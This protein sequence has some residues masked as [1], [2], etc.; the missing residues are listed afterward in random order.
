MG[1]GV[2]VAARLEGVCEPGRICFS[3]DAYTQVKSRPEASGGRPR[4]ASEY[5]AFHGRFS[6]R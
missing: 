3:E 5:H 6:W 4:V 1:D 2:N